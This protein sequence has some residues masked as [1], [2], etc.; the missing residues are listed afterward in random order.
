MT[1]RA[2]CLSIQPL[3]IK[4]VGVLILLFDFSTHGLAQQRVLKV[5]PVQSPISV[6]GRLTESEWDRPGERGFIQREPFEG[7]PPT[8]E[9]EVWFAYDQH[10]LYVA[11]RMYDQA[12]D[13][14][15]ERL[16][17]RDEDFESDFIY[18]GLDPKFDR[19]T[20]YY[21][22]TNP[23]GSI[24]DGVFYD[25]NKTDDSYD[26]V[27][28][29]AVH[30]DS[31]GWT[32]EFRIPYSQLRFPARDRY[33]WAV[34]VYRRIH[35]KNEELFLVLHPRNDDIRVSHWLPLTG[36]DGIQPPPRIELR[37][38]VAFTRKFLQSPPVASFN[39]GR[40]DPFAFGRDYLG[41]A[42]ADAKIGLSGDFTLDVSVNPDFAQ[43]E[44][45]PAVV[46]L[47]AYETFFAE[48][49]PFFIE[50][51]NILAFGRGGAA[52]YIDLNWSDPSF[53]YSRRIGRAP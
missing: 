50:G 39:Q 19:N 7:A 47:T 38:Y 9:T 27:W 34:D 16:V 31:L 14:I 52:S 48:K 43:V 53:F 1:V 11:V 45:D 18:I 40:N 23:S 8:E 3:T 10:A 12:P 29:V 44:V 5:L 46:N 51:S 26:P 4:A 25:D 15:V 22:G 28:D 2:A 33:V 17:R 42:G 24:G 37:P 49:R 35:R 30:R 13:S 32:A 41:G 21:F 6:D 20:G 36:I